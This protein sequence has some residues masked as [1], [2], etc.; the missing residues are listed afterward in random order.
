MSE[1]FQS[2]SLSGGIRWL[3]LCGS[4][5]T[6]VV[7]GSYCGQ[8][9]W[10]A[11]A[12]I[13]VF[14]I[15]AGLV[16]YLGLALM[17]RKFDGLNRLTVPYL[18]S[19]TSDKRRA[20]A[21]IDASGEGT[22]LGMCVFASRNIDQMTWPEACEIYLVDLQQLFKPK[23]DA[24]K[25]A[26]EQA[27]ILGFSASLFG[28]VLG[29]RELASVQNAEFELSSLYAAME[30]MLTSSLVGATAAFVCIGLSTILQRA[31]E[32]HIDDLRKLASGGKAGSN[33]NSDPNTFF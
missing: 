16:P 27:P 19:I 26:A 3:I 10:T 25:T 9:Q 4:M 23:L 8:E 22:A 30:I 2:E 14:V 32:K 11:S 28:M 15:I 7:A 12:V 6:A 17:I 29:V 24:V 33:S 1:P 21:D 31:C 5:L 20:L 13:G 18:A